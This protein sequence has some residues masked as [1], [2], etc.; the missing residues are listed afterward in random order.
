MYTIFREEEKYFAGKTAENRSRRPHEVS[1]RI[2]TR[3]YR[4]GAPH[5]KPR[6]RVSMPTGITTHGGDTEVLIALAE[7]SQL[8]AAV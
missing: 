2:V 6:R 4:A 3:F 7:I 8:R 5:R 1:G